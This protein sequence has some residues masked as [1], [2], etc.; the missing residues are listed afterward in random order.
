[1]WEK[2]C[3]MSG[4]RQYINVSFFTDVLLSIVIYLHRC[5][6]VHVI[7]KRVSRSCV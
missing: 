7:F 6:I 2:I 4:T 1:M 5:C 3:S